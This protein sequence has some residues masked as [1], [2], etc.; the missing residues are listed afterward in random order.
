MKDSPEEIAS[1]MNLILPVQEQLPIKEDFLNQFFIETQ[2]DLYKLKPEMIDTLKLKF[3]GKV[4]YLKDMT[5]SVKKITMGK[6]IGKLKHFKVKED[7]MSEFQSKVYIDAY[8]KDTTEKKGIY[9]ETRQCSLFVF[10]D[11]SYG[12]KGFDKYINKNVRNTLIKDNK[13]KKIFKFDFKPVLKSFLNGSTKTEILNNISKYSSKYSQA[14]SN[15]L[16]AYKN[17]KSTFVYCEF[18]KGSG[19]IVFAN[20]LKLFGFSQATG[21]EGLNSKSPRYALI[22]N[23][24]SSQKE[25]KR[26]IDRFNKPDNMYG[27]VINIVIGSKVISEGFSLENIQN[28]EILTPHWNFIIYL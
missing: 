27:E 18:V 8:R 25:I 14:I 20:L 16:D 17:K 1:I 2:K 10:P 6:S 7:F 23:F 28:E 21:K 19:A 12:S 9:S 11:G 22:T 26:L 24:T 4:S 3:K 13:L 15:I 5:S